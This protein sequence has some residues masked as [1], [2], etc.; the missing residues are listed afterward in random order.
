[1]D[2]TS[3]SL[4]KRG[5]AGA[6]S[7]IRQ[8]LIA[9]KLRVVNHVHQ[10]KV[11]TQDRPP[12]PH[13]FVGLAWRVYLFRMYMIYYSYYKRSVREDFFEYDE[14]TGETSLKVMTS[15]PKAFTW[16]RGWLKDYD[17]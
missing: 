3:S 14:E 16:E 2:R 9:R 12:N 8:L 13:E 4:I 5:R 15:P 6:V 11:Q 10:E 7:R 17:E 1:M